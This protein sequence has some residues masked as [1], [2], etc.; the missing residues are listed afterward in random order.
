MWKP[1]TTSNSS[2]KLNNPIKYVNDANDDGN[3]STKTV[4]NNWDDEDEV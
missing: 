4:V 3:G 1:K 2:G